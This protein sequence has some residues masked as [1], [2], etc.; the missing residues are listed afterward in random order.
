MDA[1]K[2]YLKACLVLWLA[3]S[4]ECVISGT[5]AHTLC[6]APLVASEAWL[7]HTLRLGRVLS[8]ELDS[9]APR[10]DRV[11][12]IQFDRA[13]LIISNIQFRQTTFTGQTTKLNLLRGQR[14]LNI[15]R[16]RQTTTMMM[17]MVF[18]YDRHLH[19]HHDD[20]SLQF[21]LD[22]DSLFS[23]NCLEEPRMSWDNRFAVN[24]VCRLSLSFILSLHSHSLSLS[25]PLCD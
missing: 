21:Y 24:V 11:Q 25:L 8:L 5:S 12:Q 14:K 18:L 20:H 19:Y 4:C 15:K 16:N 22:T 1:I 3:C 10:H 17:M 2:V 6:L 23:F 9:V 13:E 7:T